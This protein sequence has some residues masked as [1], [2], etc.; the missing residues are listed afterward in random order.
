MEDFN[1]LWT[2]PKGISHRSNIFSNTFQNVIECFMSIIWPMHQFLTLRRY[3]LQLPLLFSPFCSSL[4]LLLLLSPPSAL[5]LSHIAFPT[6]LASYLHPTLLHSSYLLSC[7]RFP[8]PLH[9]SPLLFVLLFFSPLL[10]SPLFSHLVFLLFSLLCS[11]FLISPRIFFHSPH[12]ISS[13]R[14][15]SLSSLLYFSSSPFA[16]SFSSPLS[17]FVF[18]HLFSFL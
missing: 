16:F 18:S 8:T 13:P 2:Q 6:F 9:S 10:Y 7:L 5:L 14:L 17:P 12:Y 4:L 11:I 15:S 3:F 1:L